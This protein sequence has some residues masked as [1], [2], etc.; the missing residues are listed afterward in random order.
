MGNG[1]K[2][3]FTLTVDGIKN[4]QWIKFTDEED[5]ENYFTVYRSTQY[6]PLNN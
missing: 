2:R 6:Y 5:K 3:T 1:K 4:P